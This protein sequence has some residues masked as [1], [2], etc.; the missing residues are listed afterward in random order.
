LS[1]KYHLIFI[2]INST[3]ITIKLK[4]FENHVSADLAA[5]TRGHGMW[6]ETEPEGI[7]SA[8]QHAYFA[9][10]LSNPY[11]LHE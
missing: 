3:N 10:H 2:I 8:T 1:F 7:Y 5:D 6:G 11:E 9:S 4:K